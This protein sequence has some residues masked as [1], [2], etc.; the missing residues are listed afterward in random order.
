MRFRFILLTF[1]MS[2]LAMAQMKNPAPNAGASRV[3]ARTD[4]SG[5]AIS[6]CRSITHPGNYYLSRD[7]SCPG[8]A[9]F[10]SGPGINLNLN[11]HTITYGTAGGALGAVYGI[12]NDAC[13]DTSHK[14]R[15]VPC[16]SRNAGVAAN[17]YNGSIVQ[18]TRAPSFSHALF[19]GQDNNNQTVNVHNVTITIQQ[20]GTQAFYSDFQLG[21]ILFEH[22]TVYDRVKSIN[23]P[24]QGNLSARANFQGQAVG[25]FDSKTMRTPNRI[26]NNKIVGS[27]QGGIRDTSTDSHIFQNDISMT[28]TYSNDFCVDV[29]GADQQVYSN[30]CHP[31]NGRGLHVNGRGSHVYNNLIVVT[32][33]RVNNEY[34]GCELDGAYGIQL[35]DDIQSVG[36]ITI[37][38]NSATL[39]TGSCGGAALRITGW[40]EGGTASVYGNTWIVNKTSGADQYGGLLYSM[41]DDNLTNVKFGGDTLKTNDQYCAEIPWDGAENFAVSIRGCTAPYAI[42][43]M[44]GT[45]NPSTFKVTNASHTNVACG[46]E[47]VSRGTVNGTPLRCPK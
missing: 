12:E 2:G 6:T 36:G 7:L 25:I 38:G 8:T 46:A 39:D 47:S 4:L 24:G 14:A 35:E 45:D 16:D 28:S 26:D 5:A 34:G 20:T 37:N 15:A 22:N 33:A 29:T 17:I 3:A 42:A 13:W 30:Y 18:S 9:L 44:N 23:Y 41:D 11:G 19:F 10:L 1:A 27:P 43:T 21:Q 40:P 31:V 32:E